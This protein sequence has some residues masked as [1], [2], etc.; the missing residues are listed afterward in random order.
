MNLA[1]FALK[2]SLFAAAVFL[3]NHAQLIEIFSIS[4]AMGV[5]AGVLGVLATADVK[6]QI[7]SMSIFHMS[8][9]VALIQLQSAVSVTSVNWI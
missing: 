1:A 2:F 8:L 5:I 3:M 9:G 7:A 4:L 6:K